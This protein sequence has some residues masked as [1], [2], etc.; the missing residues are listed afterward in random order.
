[1]IIGADVL[2]PILA[3]LLVVLLTYQ[4]RVR[5]RDAGYLLCLGLFSLYM[6]VAFRLTFLPL[7]LER[8]FIDLMRTG[9]GAIGSVNLIPLRL[10]A[11]YGGWMSRQAVGNL[12]LG[13][14]FG[15]GLLFITNLRPR[16]VVPAGAAFAIS[17]EVGQLL[18]NLAYG[19][20]YRIVDVND[21]LFNTIGVAVGLGLFLVSAGLYRMAFESTVGE[22]WARHIQMVFVES[23][24][25]APLLARSRPGSRE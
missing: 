7:I 12:L 22:T 1:M 24:G 2:S 23:R 18:L 20:E 17:I 14:P 10:E 3:V 13:V 9:P 11:D 5:H 21:V 4:R 25:Q 15:F 19:F 8:S 16:H 6:F